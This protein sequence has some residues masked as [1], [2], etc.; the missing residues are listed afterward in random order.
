[1]VR[2]NDP[3]FFGRVLKRED[4]FFDDWAALLS[5]MTCGLWTE[6]LDMGMV[7][8]GGATD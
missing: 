4:H 7:A 8:G 2:E 3:A 5:E 6:L 1:V